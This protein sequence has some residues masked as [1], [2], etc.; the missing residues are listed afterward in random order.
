MVRFFMGKTMKIALIGTRG[1]PASYSGFETFYENLAVRLV[2]RGHEVTTYNRRGYNP[3]ISN[4]KGVRIVTLPSIK[5]KHLETISHTFISAI[6]AIKQKHDIYYFCIAGNSPIAL[7]T[8]MLGNRVVLNVDGSDAEREKWGSFART[9]IRFSEK[10]A[11]I[12]PMVII[13]DSRAIKKRYLEYFG[14][15]TVFIPY[16]ANPWPREREKANT[17]LLKKF[18][19]ETDGYILFV[20]RMTPENR[21]DLLIKAFKKAKTNLKL[22][23]VGDA[24]YVDDY[25]AYLNKLCENDARIIRTGYLWKDDYRQISCHCRFFVLPSTID[26]TRPVLLDQMAFGNCVLVANSPAQIEVVRNCGAYFDRQNPEDSLKS[27]IEELSNN[28]DLISRYRKM[29]FRRV[30]NR[31]SWERITTQYE[32]LFLKM[33][34]TTRHHL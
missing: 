32:K 15:K 18:G 17:H 24:P 34:T 22:V 5:T 9:Y 33:L 6:H 31:Y 25:K 12:S 11:A 21:A 14:R 28:Y 29:A 7:I 26:G 13:A 19:L 3:S 8:R 10:L 4:Y 20:S 16:G 1:I 30:Q 2:K 27:K 23:L